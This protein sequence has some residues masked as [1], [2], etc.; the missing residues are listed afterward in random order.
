MMVRQMAAV[1]TACVL[2]VTGGGIMT[3]G[4]QQRVSAPDEA[5]QPI[6]TTV[7]NPN[8]VAVV[9]GIGQYQDRDDLP[10]A[11]NAVN[12]AE[13]VA[14]VLKDTLGYAPKNIIALKND[15][16]TAA[17]M[18]R[19]VQQQLTALVQPGKSD[20]FFYY[21]GH[22]MPNTQTRE[23]YLIPWD[24][25]LDSRGGI[26]PTPGTAYR[27]NDL[28]DDLKKLNAKSVTVMLE[29]CF[30]GESKG[31]AL[32][33]G[34]RP[35]V[36][37]GP[38]LDKTV[39]NTITASAASEVASDH[40]DRPHGLTT[41]YWLRAMRGEAADQ[42]GRVTPERLKHYLENNVSAAARMMGRT[43]TP[44]IRFAQPDLELARL[45]VSTLVS[46]KAKLLDAYGKLQITI[47]RGG[48]LIIDGVAQGNIPAGRIFSDEQ[49]A[50]GPHQIEIRKE[51]YLTIHEEVIVDLDQPTRK[52][53]RLVA[54]VPPPTP[55]VAS[56]R[57]PPSAPN[58]VG[59]PSPPPPPAPPQR[60]RVG[61]NVQAASL[62]SQVQPVYPAVAKTARIQGVVLLEA[63]IS[64]EG[65]VDT[66]KV[67]SGHPLLI[68]AAIDAVKQWRY[69]PTMI[70]GEPVPVV[71][72]ITV[73]FAFSSFP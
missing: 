61:G 8:A 23:G 45:P 31:A 46:G 72:T 54:S 67:I 60:I 20:V 15:L 14:R 59:Q 58:T 25:D 62:L 11:V 68:Q 73:N 40:P 38:D 21:S 52:T 50:T 44:E 49:I 47:D 26:D 39:L 10:P 19:A 34:A 16:A 35:P 48:D 63:E 27:I 70:N 9:I 2:L 64:E 32:I 56:S 24:F 65:T 57:A 22:G 30:T 33:K 7:Q 37:H 18:K 69:K 36:I 12:D 17:R 41:Y 29:A 1:L 4:A 13:A 55:A 5:D 53:Y 6:K 66:L 3:I 28:Y 71:T 43:Q 51:G 42:Q